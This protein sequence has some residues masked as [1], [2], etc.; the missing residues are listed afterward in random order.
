MRTI[1]VITL[2]CAVLLPACDSDASSFSHSSRVEIEKTYPGAGVC[3]SQYDFQWRGRRYFPFIED[4]GGFLGIGYETT[5]VNPAN[6]DG[7][8]RAPKVGRWIYHY[9]NRDGP[10][11]AIGENDMEKHVGPW[12]FWHR[13]GRLRAEG[14]FTD[15]K[16]HG[17]WRV[18]AAD[19]S[20]DEQYSGVYDNGKRT[21]DLSK[22]K[23]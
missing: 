18:W 1:L 7:P 22:P 21:G 10:K 5:E 13:N 4:D 14:S 17:E 23:R 15:G 20:G 2:F 6:P 11:L 12:R 3:N 9:D 16:M 8:K 19:G